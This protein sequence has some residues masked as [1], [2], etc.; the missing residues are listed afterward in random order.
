MSAL[1]W[2]SATP[3]ALVADAPGPAEHLTIERRALERRDI[4]PMLHAPRDAYREPA[5]DAETR[6]ALDLEFRREHADDDDER[7]DA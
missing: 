2:D 7:D 1:G 5:L 6:A 3:L 4:V